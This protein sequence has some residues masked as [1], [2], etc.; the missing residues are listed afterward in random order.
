MTRTSS[1]FVTFGLADELLAAPVEA[2]REV[3]AVPP[4]TRVPN[5]PPYLLGIIDVR[6]GS[7]PV[8]D[9]RRKF[10]L[11]PAATTDSSR[12]LVLEV[13]MAGQPITIGALADRVFEVI[14][15]DDAALQPP[16]DIGVRWQSSAIAGIGRQDGRFVI[17]LDLPAVF[18]VDT[19]ALT[20]DEADPLALPA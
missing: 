11:P 9:M 10:G 16:P 8:I 3:L 6:G 13:A 15:M 1:H 5:A 17:L 4:L 20:A 12:I 19:V 18:A 2:V 7:V 14:T